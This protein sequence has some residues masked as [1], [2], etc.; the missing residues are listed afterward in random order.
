INVKQYVKDSR[1]NYPSDFMITYRLLEQCVNTLCYLVNK[2]VNPVDACYWSLIRSYCSS[3]RDINQYRFFINRLQQIIDKL[4]LR[5]SSTI[6]S[7]ATDQFDQKQLL[8]LQ[9]AQCIRSHFIQ[10][11]RFLIEFQ[12]TLLQILSL[13]NKHIKQTRDLLILFIDDILLPLKPSDAPIIQ[14][15]Q[16][17]INEDDNNIKLD[18]SQMLFKLVESKQLNTHFEKSQTLDISNFVQDFLTNGSKSFQAVCDQLSNLLDIF[19]RNTSFN[20]TDQRLSFLQRSISIIEIFHRFFSSSIFSNFD[21]KTNLISLCSHLVQYLRPLLTFKDKLKS[22][23]L[24][25]DVAFIDAKDQFRSHLFTHF[26]TGII[27]SFERAQTFPIRLS[28]KDLRK[29]IQHIIRD[30]T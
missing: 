13:D 6:Y 24:F 19:I 7:T 12:I 16:I 23:E 1:L 27:W 29:L 26:D 21:R 8:W 15:K 20:D 22:Y 14:L 28:R 11:E 2:N 25:N 5:S 10:F 30:Q 3:L 17:L 18:L 4:Q 9:E